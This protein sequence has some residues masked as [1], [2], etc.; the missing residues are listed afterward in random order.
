MGIVTGI[1]LLLPAQPLAAQTSDASITVDPRV[2]VGFPVGDLRD[3]Q[4][5]GFAGG[6]GISVKLHS[7]IGI[8]GDVDVLLLDDESPMFGVVLAPTLDVIH[9]HGGVEFTFEPDDW[10]TIPLTFRWNLGGGATSIT[11]ERDFPDGT[12]VDFSATYPSGNTGIKIGY[13]VAPWL[14]LYGGGQLFVTFADTEETVELVKR[15][16]TT[17]PFDTLWTAALTFGAQLAF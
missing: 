16:P 1:M 2:G 10:S 9:Y 6:L 5:S 15:S 4:E 17:E 7:N 13:R 14:D 11:G 12:N 3:T 8:R